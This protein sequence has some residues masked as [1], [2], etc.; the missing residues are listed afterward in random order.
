MHIVFITSEVAGIYKIGGLADVSQSLPKALGKLGHVITVLMPRYRDVESYGG[1]HIGDIVVQFSGRTESVS[2]YE[3]TES[4]VGVR[5]IV[6]DHPLL[7]EYHSENISEVFTFYSFVAASLCS[8]S[9]R[10]FGRSADIVH[11]HDWHTGLVPV[12]LDSKNRIPGPSKQGKMKKIPTV[13]TIHNLMYTGNVTAQFLR[14]SID[15]LKSYNALSNYNLR[16]FI[17][18]KKYVSLLREG[19][20]HAT[21]ISTVSPT[22]ATEI[23][24]PH[25]V[26]IEDV[27]PRR[28]SV[29]FGV[30]NG[31]DM[32]IWNPETDRIIQ[33]N[34]G[35]TSVDILKKNNKIHLQMAFHLPTENS[36]LIGFVGRIEPRQKGIDLVLPILS[37][38]VSDKNVQII[39]LGTGEDETE[40]SLRDIAAKFSKH[41]VFINTFDDKIAH[42]IYAGCD[43]LLVPSKFEPC[44]LTQLIAMRYGTLPIVRKTG[45][46]ADTVQDGVTGFVFTDYQSDQLMQK[47][48]TARST[49][50]TEPAIWS[51]MVKTA[52]QRDFSWEKSATSY[53]H[54]YEEAM[55]AVK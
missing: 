48:A 13:F 33:S 6:L 35:V 8:D 32:E 40:K 47:I 55:T 46:L 25:P 42:Q 22:Y 1:N 16:E 50:A 34:Y 20:E 36:F 51:G 23:A 43:A 29:F 24:I 30:L 5:V 17:H 9:E 39:F 31:I 37:N 41:I 27:L 21:I 2:L 3:L 14:S 28:K 52:M 38:V 18:E 11:C 54:M 19:L 15:D 44:G 7:K 4:Y 53:V 10:Y 49:W 26:P 12:L 45:G